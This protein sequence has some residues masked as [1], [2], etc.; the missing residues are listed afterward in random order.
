MRACGAA[1]L[2]VG[3]VCGQ[4]FAQ[5]AGTRPAPGRGVA[6]D[7][8]TYA[9]DAAA[10][11]AWR[12][13]EGS[14]GATMADANG[15]RALRMPCNFK[16]T[17]I[18]RA[19]WDKAVQ[20]DLTEARGIRFTVRCSDPAAASHFNLYLRSGKGW[21][22][23]SFSSPAG[24]A[25]GTVTI[26]KTGTA[27]EGAPAGWGKIDTIRIAAWRG[28]DVD[29]EMY[30]RDL[31]VAAAERLA[32]VVVVRGES[33]AAR[34]KDELGSVC[35][36]S[37]TMAQRL[38][39]LGLGYCLVSDLDLSAERLRGKALVI[40]PHNPGMPDAPAG[41]LADYLKSGGKL[42]AFYGLPAGLRD[43]AG[44]A[45]GPHLP[46]R[47]PGQFASVRPA[48][49]G[50]IAGLPAVVKQSSWN[51]VQAKPVEGRSRVAA[52]WCDG[53]GQPTG[54]AAVVVSDTCAV[55][56]HV[57]LEDDLPNQRRL[58]M[59]MAG[60]FAP[61]LWDEAARA[62]M[63]RIG[64]MGPFRNLSDA[65]D[66]VARQAGAS[67]EAREALRKAAGLQ[68]RAQEAAR[69]RRFA[70]AMDLAEQANASVR[71]AAC[72][73]Q[74]PLPGEHRAFW[75]HSAFGVA[76]MDWD[77]AIRI[78]ADNGFTDILPNMLWGGAA[79]YE[80]N[81][82]PLAPDARDRGDQLAKC[83]AACRKYGVACHVWKV[84]WNMGGSAPREFVQRMESQGRTQ[85]DFDGKP[86]SRWLCPSHGE[87]QQLEIDAM[88]EVA[89]RYAVDGV[90][91]D[92]IRYPGPENCFCAGCRERF[93][94]V[95]G[96][97]VNDWPRDVRRDAALSA[98]WLDFRRDNIT[99]V[100]AAVSVAA[101]QAR[102]GIQ[103]SAAVFPNWPTDRNTIGQDWKLWCEKGYLDFVC[104]MDYTADTGAFAGMVERQVKWAG[105]VPCYPGIG[106][107]CWGAKG[108][109]FTL[110]D[111]IAVTRR[112]GTGGFA[113]FN[114]AA[115]EASQVVPACG[116]G[117]TKKE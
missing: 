37:G 97:K 72:R 75:C 32:Q 15:R 95:I 99:R 60:H 70:E 115:P 40:L 23:A 56:T 112:A 22:V 111:Q 84:N 30:V 67:Q 73:I 109:L 104:P 36:Y 6:I 7:P 64:R 98:K 46:Q 10:R 82:L 94:K 26:D 87:N 110:F 90:H 101:R 2:V 66:Q 4:S 9:D 14:A 41:V 61:A 38:E 49:G 79:Y 12:A 11:A 93:E 39:E 33:A 85:V 44:I 89:R 8:L 59:A 74:K 81:V 21:Y 91:F 102:P 17:R 88:V 63:D 13:M 106:L 52:E 16:G 20:L 48:K 71:E 27:I 108:D 18:D 51:I 83:L 55:M 42:L 31:A 117:I 68:T 57:L 53:N 76:G 1:V 96:R 5:S 116:L 107:S 86:M 29:A 80:S 19:Y 50:P 43:A 105:K 34:D 100:V 92:Y 69:S 3:L 103:V 65:N 58:L 78:L 28:G 113:I 24:P 45:G 25:W 47:R 77:S 114:Y 54:Y 35:R 62:T